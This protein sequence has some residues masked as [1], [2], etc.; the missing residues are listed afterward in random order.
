MKIKILINLFLLISMELLAQNAELR[1]TLDQDFSDLGTIKI[2]AEQGNVAAQIKLADA[3]LSNFKSADALKWYEAAAKQNSTEGKY[4][5]GNMLIFGRV[6]IPNEQRVQAKPIEGLKWTYQAATSGHKEAWRNMAKALEG[7]IGCSTN[8]VEAYAWLSLLA[9]TGDIVGRVEMN[10]LALKITSE[11]IVNAKNLAQKM[12]SGHWPP[13][14]AQKNPEADLVLKLN[15][16]I[17]GGAHPL[18]T[19]N[20]KTVAAGET[21]SIKIKK[22]N[23]NVRCLKIDSDS[24]TI[25]VDGE[26]ESRQLRMQ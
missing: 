24:V 7:G 10:N 26:T 14:P 1:G 15:G 6:G 18:A 20:G 22:E 16:L 5:L 12:E 3:Y 13:L 9:D 2:Q 4:Q 11:Q 21:I 8:L 23:L 19:I 17:P 25:L